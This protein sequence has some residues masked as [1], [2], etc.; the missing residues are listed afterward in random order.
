MEEVISRK[1]NYLFY[2]KLGPKLS[3][4]YFFM[5]QVFSYWDIKLIPVSYK[6]F[7]NHVKQSHQHLMVVTRDL[8]SQGQFKI[9]RKNFLDL[10]IINKKVTLFN[11]SSFGE[12]LKF[13]QSKGVKYYYHYALPLDMDE[14]CLEM[15]KVI[16]KNGQTKDTWPGGVRVGVPLLA[17]VL[18][19]K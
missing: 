3:V 17:D 13:I 5:A 6:E 7:L 11:L 12:I 19:E 16:K 4:D 8:K 18:K 10:A 2:L 1:E 15:A 14:V 9:L